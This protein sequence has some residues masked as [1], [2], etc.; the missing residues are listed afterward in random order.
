MDINE[1]RNSPGIKDKKETRSKFIAC[2]F[3]IMLAI[4]SSAQ[5]SSGKIYTEGLK[6]SEQDAKMLEKKL[7]TNPNDMEIRA[8]LLG[9]YFHHSSRSSLARLERQKHILWIIQNHPES[10]IAGLPYC[11]L[12][13]ALDGMAYNEAK[14]LW[15]KQVSNNKKNT[16]IIGNAADFLVL[17]DEYLAEELLKEAKAI[18]PNNP[19]WQTALAN[20]YTR[21]MRKEKG[22]SR[23]ELA[24]KSLKENENAFN[25]TT[26]ESERFYLLTDL[27]RNAFD[28]GDLEKAHKYAEDLLK[29][30]SKYK[31]NWNYGNAIHHGNQILGRIALASGDMGKAKKY[32]LESANTTGTPQLNSFGPNMTLA[33]ELLEK[34]ERDIVINYFKICRN[35]WKMGKKKLR[36]WADVVTSGGMPD[37]GANLVY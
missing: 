23:M 28:A 12:N 21:K 16:T 4:I 35:F 20:L 14:D 30:S 33:K 7:K 24:K 29:K 8:K 5:A 36:K 34:G 27:A 31:K 37:F 19:K 10:E 9:Y 1:C 22:K 26:D 15:L 2:I 3:L 18:E 25:S 32:L 6:L 11:H 13:P 17:Y